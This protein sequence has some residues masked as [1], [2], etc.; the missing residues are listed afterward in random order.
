[1]LVVVLILMFIGFG[2]L[3]VASMTGTVM[4]AWASVG[5]SAL[6]AAVLV[7]NWRAR[8]AAVP[9]P[10]VAR[11]EPTSESVQRPAGAAVVVK[12][13][14]DVLVVDQQ[15]RFHVPGC[16]ELAGRTAVALNFTPCGACTPLSTLAGAQ[17]TQQDAAGS[18]A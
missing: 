5:V 15:P 1:M 8:S 3:R 16:P 10:R 13:D 9:P 11:E 7:T 12:L 4:W 14:G 17:A 18:R 2:M 6:A